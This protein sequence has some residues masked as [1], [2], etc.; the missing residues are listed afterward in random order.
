MS[1]M[2][3]RLYVN[4]PLG[5]GQSVPLSAD[6]AHYLFGVMRLRVGDELLLFNGRDGEWR[7]SVTVATKRTACLSAH[8]QERPLRLPPDLWLLFAPL[9]KA[10][11]ALVVEKA[12][13]MGVAR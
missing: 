9:K 8:E 4:H 6:Q 5:T 12:V 3:V 1:R 13:E 7:A 2:R 11:T 10:R